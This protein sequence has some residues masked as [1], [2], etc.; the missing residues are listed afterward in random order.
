MLLNQ[1]I[2]VYM[3]VDIHIH[4]LCSRTKNDLFALINYLKSC[5][6]F[7]REKFKEIV[8]FSKDD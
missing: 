4:T 6:I 7:E 2:C 3:S 8:H 1:N 5:L